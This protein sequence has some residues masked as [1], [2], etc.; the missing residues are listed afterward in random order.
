MNLDTLFK[1]KKSSLP[2]AF[3]KASLETCFL[4]GTW[5]YLAKTISFASV[6]CLPTLSVAALFKKTQRSECADPGKALCRELLSLANCLA[7]QRISLGKP[8][9]QR[10]AS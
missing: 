10:E 1:C 3:F 8:A 9:L 6:M 2:L 4:G 5:L 7:V